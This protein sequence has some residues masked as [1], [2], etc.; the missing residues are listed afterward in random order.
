[1]IVILEEKDLPRA[2]EILASYGN[3]LLYSK[4][5]HC[6]CTFYAVSEGAVGALLQIRA[7]LGQ[8]KNQKMFGLI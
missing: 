7:E 8:E 6:G 1:M 2:R 4:V 5:S 3:R